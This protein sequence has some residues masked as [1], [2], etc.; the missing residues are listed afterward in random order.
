MGT[1]SFTGELTQRVARLIA[2]SAACRDLACND[3]I[4]QTV[5]RF[6][7][8]ECY[9]AQLALTQAIRVHPGQL[10]QAL[11]RDDN[12]FPFS[13]PRPPTVLFAMWALSDF[14][15]HN[16][17]TRL[18]PRS[19]K[20]DDEHPAQEEASITI[21][22]AKGS[23]LLW[24]GAIYHGAGTNKADTFRAGALFGYNLGWLRQYE[25]QYLAVPPDLA[26]TLSPKLQDLLGYSSHGY[27][28][29]YEN[30]DGRA[31][32]RDPHLELPAATDLFTG[33]LE[34]LPRNRR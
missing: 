11:H 9:H 30:Q 27:L 2:R 5:D 20:F 8:G 22:M 23:V 17:A 25:N 28:G 31:L 7:E 33:E 34:L 29:S 13:H 32:L 26:R 24:E 10:S 14:T 3:L 15:E 12:V 1:G 6:F 19:H 4:L 16:G 21:Q 18:I